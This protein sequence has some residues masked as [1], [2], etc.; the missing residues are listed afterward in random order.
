M[1]GDR[2]LDFARDRRIVKTD[3][4]SSVFRLRPVYRTAHFVL[5]TRKTDLP[6]ARLGVVAAKRLAPRAV[7]RNTIKRVTRELF[8]QT[9]L[10]SIDC[11]VRLSQ[12]VNTKQGPATSA[13]LKRVLREELTRLFASQCKPAH[14]SGAGE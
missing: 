12:P 3:E 4:F 5:Y 11:I 10:P 8:R 14:R 13:S 9:A 7:T 6:H 2:S 1:T